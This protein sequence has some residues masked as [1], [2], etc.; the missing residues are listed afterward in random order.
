MLGA[1]SEYV[2]EE[3]ALLGLSVP[4]AR[5]YPR[6]VRDLERATG[7]D[8]GFQEAGTLVVSCDAADR[9]WLAG[10]RQAQLEQGLSLEQLT[11]RQARGLEPMLSPRISGAFWAASDHQVNPRDLA[12]AYL[13]ALEASP[14][15]DV[16]REWVSELIWDDDRVEG[17]RT[18]GPTGIIAADE[19]VVANG[20]SSPELGALPAGLRLPI[21]A[22]HGDVLRLASPAAAPP[23]T[24]RTIRG[25]VHG[26]SVYIVARADGEAVVGATERED[27]RPEVLVGGVYELL[28]DAREL[29]PGIAELELV[30]VTA[31][32]RPGTPDNAPILGRVVPG[33]IANTGTHRHGV[34]LSAANAEVVANLVTT[35]ETSV[36]VSAFDPWRFSHEHAVEEFRAAVAVG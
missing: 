24:S 4:A 20:L 2:F 27:D 7:A 10:L 11:T 8:V 29:L 6:L 36:D 3:N 26:R 19:T 22:V 32:A 18:S 21:R 14:R 31:R 25:L 15:A 1:V 5:R 23:L 28:R 12:A 17:V 9:Q 33:L 34:L 30:E 35:G 16:V 13:A